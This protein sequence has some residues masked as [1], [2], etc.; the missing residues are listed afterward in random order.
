MG[1]PIRRVLGRR[2]KPPFQ[3]QIN[4][5][6]PP[7]VNGKLDVSLYLTD[8]FH[9]RAMSRKMDDL[10][11]DSASFAEN[12][13]VYFWLRKNGAPI[14]NKQIMSISHVLIEAF[15]TKDPLSFFDRI[16]ANISC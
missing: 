9:R 2:E 16:T 11:V 10:E 14:T 8:G 5:P 13:G 7:F 1:D 6:A 15:S 4:P 3:S 12:A